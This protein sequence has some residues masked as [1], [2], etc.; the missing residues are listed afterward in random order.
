MITLK[1]YRELTIPD[2]QV[3]PDNPTIPIPVE[4]LLNEDGLIKPT[5]GVIDT[6]P[7]TS[8][9]VPAPGVQILGADNETVEPAPPLSCVHP[10]TGRVIPIHGESR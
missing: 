10:R 4:E 1:T 5:P 6:D 3:Y 2:P 8:L 7:V 9:L